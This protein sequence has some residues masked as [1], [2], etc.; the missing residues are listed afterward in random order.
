[1]NPPTGPITIPASTDKGFISDDCMSV[2]PT[3]E[4]G[5]I[6]KTEEYDTNSDS[7]DSEHSSVTD[8]CKV[9]FC[10]TVNYYS[11]THNSIFISYCCAS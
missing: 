8:K 11:V 1:M 2:S 5:N 4:I 9:H 7:D 10:V 3:Q 6:L